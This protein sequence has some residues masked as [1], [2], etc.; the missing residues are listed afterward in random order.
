MNCGSRFANRAARIVTG[1]ALGVI[2][3]YFFALGVTFLPII[4]IVLAAPVIGPALFFLNSKILN[5]SSLDF[6]VSGG[7]RCP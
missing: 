3:L 4:G 5:Q 7:G 1:I 2:S 6:Y